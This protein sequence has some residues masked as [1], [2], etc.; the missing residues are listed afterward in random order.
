MTKAF[1]AD[2]GGGQKLLAHNLHTTLA[3]ATHKGC[4]HRE[5]GGRH[6]KGGCVDLAL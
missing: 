4:L 6:S 2:K 1:I 3:G 5:D